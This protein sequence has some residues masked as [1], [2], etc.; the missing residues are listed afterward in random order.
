MMSL[1]DKQGYD[2]QLLVRYLLGSLPNEEAEHLDELSIADD[3]FA[4]RLNAV[5]NDLVDAYARGDLS[6]E[7]QDRFKSFYLSSMNRREKVRFA[8]TLLGYENRTADAQIAPALSP[9]RSAP[10]EGPSQQSSRRRFFPLPPLV[11]QWTLAGLALVMLLAGGL[12]LMD[13]LRLRKQVTEAEAGRAALGEREQQMKTQ[14][15]EQRSA[16]ARTL[17]ELEQAREPQV[18]LDQLRT[19][20]LFLLPATRGAG[21]I[22]TISVPTGTDLAVLL[23]ALESDD[24]P[25]YRAELKDPANHHLIWR[26]GNLKSTSGG[27]Y[28]AVSISFRADVLKPQN[29]LVELTGVPSRGAPE[30]ISTYPFRAMLK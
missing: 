24:F 14:L 6:G 15:T 11:P 5:E 20:S 2:D 30:F 10:S 18:N 3:E 27:E 9:F 25:A 4:L 28:K 23:L 21:Q 12:L 1:S 26:S 19:I 22:P 8:E 17:K 16:S 7:T 29:Y 13:N